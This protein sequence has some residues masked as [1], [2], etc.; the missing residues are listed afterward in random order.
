[1]DEM[2]RR[3]RGL[4]DPEP[5]EEQRQTTPQTG[6]EWFEQVVLGRTPEMTDDGGDALRAGLGYRE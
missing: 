6:R 4:P 3:L 1:M 2:N 5:G